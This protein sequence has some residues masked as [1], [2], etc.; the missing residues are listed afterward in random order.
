MALLHLNIHKPA[1]EKIPF[2]AVI[3]DELLDEAKRLRWLTTA[4]S[5]RPIRSYYSKEKGRPV[6]ESLARWVWSQ[7]EGV[8]TD[9]VGHL[10]GDLLNCLRSNLV[11]LRY[12]R[13][14]SN[15]GI[16]T[17]VFPCVELYRAEK[18]IPL[19][20]LK[21]KQGRPIPVSEEQL[22]TLRHLRD[23]VGAGLST[24]Q[25]NLQIVA[26]EVGKP[27]SWRGLKTLEAELEKISTGYT[28]PEATQ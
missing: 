14:G 3:D 4:T 20:G 2:F 22:Q 9:Y 26:E 8:K 12:N 23:T 21:V 24:H 25:F 16:C 28:S 6:T 5:P 10:D 13:L 18:G 11:A 27:L 19:E 17:S 15:K 1:T 7:T